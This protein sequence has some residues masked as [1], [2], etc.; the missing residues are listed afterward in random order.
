MSLFKSKKIHVEHEQA[1]KKPDK[2]DIPLDI[3]QKNEVLYIVA[4]IAGVGV[5]DIRLSISGDV[6]SIK[7]ERFHDGEFNV[8]DDNFFNK[9]CHWG[10]FH[11]SVVF[12][13]QA[14]VKKVTASFKNGI[15]TIRVP[16]IEEENDDD[17]ITKLHVS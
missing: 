11:R 16:I 3:F 1:E 8:L 15:L 4:L 12:P 14:D 13:V 10:N 9:E 17:E 6:L 2:G 5:D 7:G